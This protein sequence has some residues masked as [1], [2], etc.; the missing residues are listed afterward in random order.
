[1]SNNEM[2]KDRYVVF[3]AILTWNIKG[4]VNPIYNIALGCE[5]NFRV[6]HVS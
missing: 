1:M 4:T 3:S 5:W 2:E 6:I